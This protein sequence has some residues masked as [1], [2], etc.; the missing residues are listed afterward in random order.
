MFRTD[1]LKKAI[2]EILKDVNENIYYRKAP[3]KAT[4]PYITFFLKHTKNEHQYDYF[5]EVHI[6]S[7]NI[8][9]A[10]EIADKIEE[11]DKCNYKDDYQSF[12]LD[13]ES[14][15]NIENDDK[16]VQHVVLLFNLTFFDK[17]G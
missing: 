14:R 3:T 13:I 5:W 7:K 12:D 9:T 10:E 17:K 15:N 1:K 2:V 16:E 11:F 6:W 8:K 4:Y